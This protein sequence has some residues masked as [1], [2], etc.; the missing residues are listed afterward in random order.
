MAFLFFECARISMRKPTFTP[1][2]ISGF[3]E[4]CKIDSGQ[5]Y[6][7]NKMTSSQFTLG[8]SVLVVKWGQKTQCDMCQTSKC[9]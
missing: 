8:L 1:T 9:E 5:L 4:A 2:R 3:K 6:I 7:L